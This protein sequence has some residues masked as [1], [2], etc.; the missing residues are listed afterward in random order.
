MPDAAAVLP[1]PDA[2]CLCAA[3]AAGRRTDPAGC[4]PAHRQDGCRD[5]HRQLAAVALPADRGAAQRRGEAAGEVPYTAY[6]AKKSY[7]TNNKEIVE[8]FTKAI[9]KGEQ[10]VKEHSAKEIAEE[11][12]SFFPDTTVE[13]LET[14]VQKY[15]DIDA[16]KENPVLKEEAFDKLQEIMTMAGELSKKAPYDKIVNNSFAEKFN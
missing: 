16:W 1:R 15:K 13:S 7:I 3:L 12:K 2:G 4:G 8:K 11:I 10:W 5:P 9:Y 14:S 6:C